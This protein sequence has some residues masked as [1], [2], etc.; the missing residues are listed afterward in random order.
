M[1]LVKLWDSVRFAHSNWF[2]TLR[3]WR[4]MR[5]CAALRWSGSGSRFNSGGMTTAYPFVRAGLITT[6]AL[7]GR[8]VERARSKSS[9]CA[10]WT[11][12]GVSDVASGGSHGT[13]VRA[14][15]YWTMRLVAVTRA[16]AR[17]VVVCPGGSGCGVVV[18]GR[19][20][21]GWAATSIAGL[22]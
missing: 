11:V 4:V 22:E 2:P 3:G 10:R 15:N 9:R 21:T 20:A 16:A 14:C 1:S 7:V 12:V 13:P 19:C 8:S 5:A 17:R 6:C 18:P